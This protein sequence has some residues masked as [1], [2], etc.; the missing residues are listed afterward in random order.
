MEWGVWKSDL[1]YDMVD[2][3]ER[4]ATKASNQVYEIISSSNVAL[5]GPINWRSSMKLGPPFL[6]FL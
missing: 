3:H 1:L 5:E 6:K 4:E 2:F